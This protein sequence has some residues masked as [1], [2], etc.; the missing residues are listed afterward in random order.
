[1]SKLSDDSSLRS[2]SSNGDLV[3]KST[4]MDD[5]QG[6]PPRFDT[7]ELELIGSRDR[8]GG[9]DSPSESNPPQRANVEETR[10]STPTES[11]IETFM[12]APQ[13]VKAALAAQ[14]PMIEYAD[15]N[16]MSPHVDSILRPT[17]KTENGD[18]PQTTSVSGRRIRQRGGHG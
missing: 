15:D 1:M 8:S 10:I 13:E 3:P 6:M 7:E 16:L 14:F 17:K 5:A 12:T 9:E 18:V 4:S 11:S 2:N